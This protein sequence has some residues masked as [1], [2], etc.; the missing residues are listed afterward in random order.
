MEKKIKKEILI[1]PSWY[2]PDGGGFFKIHAESLHSEYFNVNVLVNRTIGLTSH[3][4]ND[5]IT[6]GNPREDQE[7]SINVFRTSM[8][9]FPLLEK[10]N[11]NRWI[12]NSIIHFKNYLKKYPKPDIIIAH[13]AIW[14]GV[15]AARIKSIY[16]IPFIIVEHRGRF[17]SENSFASSFRKEFHKDVYIKAYNEASRIVCVSDA[18]KEGLIQI[19][20]ITPEMFP[21]IPNM[22]D[23]DF[24]TLPEYDRELQPFI[25]LSIGMLEKVKGYDLLLNAFAQF[26]DV[27]EGEFFLRIGGRGSEMKNLKR[28]ANDLGIYDRVSFQGQLSRE[29]VRDEMHRSN[30]FISSSHFE[31][32]GV[33]LIE[34]ASTGLPLIATNSGGPQSII[35]EDNGFLCEA[36]NSDSLAKVMEKVYFEYNKFNPELIRQ[37][38]VN[39]YSRAI[40]SGIYHDLINDVVNEK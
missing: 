25:F 9:N 7:N 30:V 24:F 15:V 35:N 32:F 8:L 17:I 12:N 38:T 23:T 37:N 1:I 40:I 5:I 29:R 13:S 28:L 39:K 4:F 6:V 10:L 27:M 36:G 22:A 26:T 16:N 21:V 14:A 11:L 3:K 34:A 2:P 33:A 19:T 31:S 18:L 20:G